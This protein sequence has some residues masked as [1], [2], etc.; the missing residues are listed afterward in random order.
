MEAEFPGQRWKGENRGRWNVYTFEHFA[1][2]SKGAFIFPEQKGTKPRHAEVSDILM[3]PRR[4]VFELAE[5]TDRETFQ[6]LF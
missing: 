4:D 3:G 1:C 5:R 6:Y 2:L